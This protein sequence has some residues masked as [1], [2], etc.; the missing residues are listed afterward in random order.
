MQVDPDAGRRSEIEGLKKDAAAAEAAILQIQSGL[1]SPEEMNGLLERL[2]A[3]NTTIIIPA[4][5]VPAFKPADVFVDKVKNAS[6]K[7]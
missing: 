4:H 1:V 3:K 5:N 6:T 2:L 7:A